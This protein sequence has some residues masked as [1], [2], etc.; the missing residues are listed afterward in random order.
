MSQLSL[1]DYELRITRTARG[2]I[3]PSAQLKDGRV[4]GFV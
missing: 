3:R 1:S 2:W 4:E